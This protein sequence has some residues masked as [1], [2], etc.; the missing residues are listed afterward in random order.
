MDF[1][2]LDGSPPVV[3]CSIANAAA[4]TVDLILTLDEEAVV[5]WIILKA[6]ATSPSAKEVRDESAEGNGKHS[7]NGEQ[8]H[9]DAN[10]PVKY[11]PTALKEDTAYVAYI[12]AEDLS[13]D[14]CTSG[15][16]SGFTCTDRCAPGYKCCQDDGQR[17]VPTSNDCTNP[18]ATA[19]STCGNGFYRC[20]NFGERCIKTV[21]SCPSSC[22]N[23]SPVKA[24]SFSTIDGTPPSV[25]E[26]QANQVTSSGAS[27][28]FKLDEV[29]VVYY[30]TQAGNDAAPSVAELTGGSAPRAIAGASGSQTG[31]SKDA[32]QQFTIANLNQATSYKL[33]VCTHRPSVSRCSRV[34]GN[35]CLVR[36]ATPCVC[37][38]VCVCV[39]VSQ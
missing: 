20:A 23:T 17:C 9:P 39:R 31:V 10:V 35:P 1:T 8:S 5:W 4:A 27:I 15:P 24:C 6:S 19:I 32:L 33:Y 29:G 14:T 38:C 7:S 25:Y 21:E 13:D 37:V 11:T 18:P 3:T 36:H 28:Q 26:L 2:T 16:P 12:V 30:A 34:V 22:G